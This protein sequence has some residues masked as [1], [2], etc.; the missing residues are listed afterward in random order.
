MPPAGPAMPVRPGRRRCAEPAACPPGHFGGRLR[1]DCAMRAAASRAARPTP[2][3]WRCRHSDEP[4]RKYVE[5]PAMS[6]IR[7]ETR[8]P[9]QDS[10]NP[11]DSWRSF[12]RRPASPARSREHANISRPGNLPGYARRNPLALQRWPGSRRVSARGSHRAECAAVSGNGS[13]PS[14]RPPCA[15]AIQCAMRQ[16]KP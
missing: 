1:A 3:L 10:A 14:S 9:V 2:P 13:R 4:P 11:S 6:V 15:S 12:K 16:A 7:L 8:P 5:L